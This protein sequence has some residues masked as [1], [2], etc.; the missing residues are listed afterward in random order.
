MIAEYQ[1]GDAFLQAQQD[2]DDWA[3]TSNHGDT[4][5]FSVWKADKIGSLHNAIYKSCAYA[6][7]MYN[8]TFV[9]I[10]GE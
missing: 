1:F 2:G 10:H 8:K 9:T 3:V 4:F 7:I 5:Y 6:H